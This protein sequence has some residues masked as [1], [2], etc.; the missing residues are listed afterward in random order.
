MRDEVV[1]RAV[2]EADLELFL[3]QEHDPEAVRRS[4]FT[5]RDRE[6]FMRHWRTRILGDPAVLSLTALVDGEPAGNLGAWS[7]EGRRFVG[8][9]FDR[10]YWGRGI[11][12]AALRL[13]LTR[14]TTRPLYADAYVGNT[15]SIRVLEK[16]GFRRLGPLHD[17]GP[18]HVRYVLDAP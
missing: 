13:F 14:E 2:E 3:A 8:Y 4:A 11:G 7:D 16:C 18:E 1:L 15:G 5:P 6:T 9:G 17:D 10:R 12:T